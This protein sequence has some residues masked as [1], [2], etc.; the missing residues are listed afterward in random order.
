VADGRSDG[1]MLQSAPDCH[2]TEVTQPLESPEPASLI[3]RR[4]GVDVPAI[5]WL[6]EDPRGIVLTC[7]AGSGHKSS[8]GVLALARGCV[9]GHAKFRSSD[10]GRAGDRWRRSLNRCQR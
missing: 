7:H 3:V 9:V 2:R 1:G 10:P 4:D 8:P 6:R 5:V